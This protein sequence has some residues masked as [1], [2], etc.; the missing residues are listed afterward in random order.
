MEHPPPLFGRVVR[1]STHGHS[2]TSLHYMNVHHHTSAH[3][4]QANV[5][6]SMQKPCSCVQFVKNCILYYMSH[7]NPYQVFQATCAVSE[8]GMKLNVHRIKSLRITIVPSCTR[9]RSFV[10]CHWH[11]YSWCTLV[12]VQ[13][14]TNS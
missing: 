1:C 7:E 13:M 3:V 6:D 12:T 11:C 4:T 10:C 5:W 9:K 8:R 14:T 2:L